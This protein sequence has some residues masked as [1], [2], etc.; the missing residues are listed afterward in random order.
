[1]DA[2]GAARSPPLTV[3][4]FRSFFCFLA[5]IALVSGGSALK[6]KFGAAGR[7]SGQGVFFN[8]G[9]LAAP[10]P[11]RRIAWD[12]IFSGQRRLFSRSIRNKP[13]SGGDIFA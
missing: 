4:K 2:H 3:A 9:A 7:G 12:L 1:M 6:G 11:A 5:I 8:K 10:R 13:C